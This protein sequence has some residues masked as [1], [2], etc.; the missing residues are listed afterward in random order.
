MEREKSITPPP[1]RAD[2]RV[3]V[4][5]VDNL[6]KHQGK[7]CFERIHYEM[8]WSSIQMKWIE[9][10]E[11]E[12]KE[13]ISLEEK[14]I[15][16]VQTLDI[17]IVREGLDRFLKPIFIY[18]KVTLKARIPNSPEFE[19]MYLKKIKGHKTRNKWIRGCFILSEL[20]KGTA[21]I[22]NF[23]HAWVK[24]VGKETIVSQDE[25]QKLMD[26]AEVADLMTENPKTGKLSSRRIVFNK[27]L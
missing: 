7:W 27:V 8:H 19:N 6:V 12:K 5:S 9:Q 16:K 18:L 14:G 23:Q 11:L 15:R 17:L 25:A 10:K 13:Y 20:D 26:N 22:L 21:Q 3:K 1:S 2:P 4:Y 24:R